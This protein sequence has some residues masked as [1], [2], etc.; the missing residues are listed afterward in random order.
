LIQHPKKLFSTADVT[1]NY[2]EGSPNGEPV[3][4]IHGVGSRWQPFLP[5][6][7]GLSEHFHVFAIDLRGHGRSGHTPGNYRLADYTRDIQAFI[8]EKVQRPA[9]IYG[10]SLG[11]LVAIHLAAQHPQSVHKLILG[12]PPL[13]YHNTRIQDIF[14]QKAF[15]DL[16][17]FMLAYPDP[18]QMSATLAQN[19]PN[20]SPERREER[21]RSLATLDPDVIRAVISDD[22][23]N[24]VSLASLISQVVCPVLLLRGDPVLGSALREED[25]TFALEHFA[26]ITLLAMETIGHGIV[27]IALLPQLIEFAGV[28]MR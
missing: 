18:E 28:K 25:V 1:L 6:M 9:V 10:H 16:L 7:P 2:V 11:A 8:A 24:R 15:Q 19:W 17:D 14:W 20:M 27:P 4:L 5:I 13:F 12:D 21:V 26:D 3:I 22:L 23:M